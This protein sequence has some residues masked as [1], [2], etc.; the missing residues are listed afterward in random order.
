MHKGYLYSE[1][2]S[3]LYHTDIHNQVPTDVV[4]V[5]DD[6]ALIIMEAPSKGLKVASVN[7]S[8][9]LVPHLEVLSAQDVASLEILWRNTQLKVADVE[10]SKIQDRHSTATGKLSDWRKYRN[11]LRDWPGNV[12]FPNIEYRPKTPKGCNK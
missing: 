5:T 4:P 10:I 6:V 11:Q 9:S 12:N 1:K 7:G 3:A 8:I 2:Q